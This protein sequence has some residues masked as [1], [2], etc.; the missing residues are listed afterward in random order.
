MPLGRAWKLKLLTAWG[1]RL[2]KKRR[3]SFMVS[4]VF[5]F[6]LLS[7]HEDSGYGMILSLAMLLFLSHRMTMMEM[8]DEVNREPLYYGVC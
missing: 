2:V 3:E 6:I 8:R 7:V 1:V 4:R 5:S